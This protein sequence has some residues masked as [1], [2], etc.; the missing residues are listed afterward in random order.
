MKQS[1]FQSPGGQIH[2]GYNLYTYGIQSTESSIVLSAIG[3][4]SRLVQHVG[5]SSFR[6]GTKMVLVLEFV[7]LAQNIHW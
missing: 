4:T 5:K 6:A 3:R 2:D 1:K 7:T